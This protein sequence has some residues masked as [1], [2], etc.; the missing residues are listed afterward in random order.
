MSLKYAKADAFELTS[1]KKYNYYHMCLAYEDIIA[2]IIEKIKTY[3]KNRYFN[4]ISIE[5]N[6]DLYMG[7]MSIEIKRKINNV[8]N[9]SEINFKTLN[10]DDEKQIYNILNGIYRG[11]I[12]G[13]YKTNQKMPTILYN[14]LR[15]K[16]LKKFYKISEVKGCNELS[17]TYKILL[18]DE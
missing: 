13:K 16:D 9:I 11:I 1:K 5:I 8:V 2:A 4:E 10:I 18:K 3:L 12:D 15:N 7:E 14:L 6:S 17:K